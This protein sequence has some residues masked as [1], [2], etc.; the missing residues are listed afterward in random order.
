MGPAPAPLERVA[1][2][3]RHQLLL[4]GNSRR[5]L[6]E[7]CKELRLELERDRQSRRVR[8]SLDVDPADSW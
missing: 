3:F 4:L 5:K 1:G 8:W 2:R 6:L 7:L